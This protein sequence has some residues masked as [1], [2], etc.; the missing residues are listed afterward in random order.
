MSVPSAAFTL[1]TTVTVLVYGLLH[2]EIS[3]ASE[4][5]DKGSLMSTLST[6]QRGLLRRTVLVAVAVFIHGITTSGYV[7]EPTGNLQ[8]TTAVLLVSA[9]MHIY[10][11][12]KIWAS[13]FLT[14]IDC[15][16]VYFRLYAVAVTHENNR[17]Q[18]RLY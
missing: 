6:L 15:L 10:V 14:S 5:Q 12:G 4:E 8:A 2:F 17:T 7:Q 1:L 13:M 9:R 16:V 3:I 11:L 18:L